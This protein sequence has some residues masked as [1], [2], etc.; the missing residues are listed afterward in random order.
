MDL[1]INMKFLDLDREYEYFDY[2]DA[3]TSVFDKKNFINGEEINIFEKQISFYLGSKYAVAVSSGTDALMVSIMA[4]GIENPV[5]LTTPYSF[6]STVEV[7]LRLN[8]R[9]IVFCDIKD[10][11]NIDIEKAKEII[12]KRHIDI[13]LPVHLF[14]RPCELDDEILSLCKQKG[15][16]VIEDAAQSI[17]S[18]YGDKKVG[19]IGDMGCFSFFPAKTLGCAGDGG[20]V[21]TDSKELYEKMLMIRN[22]GSVEKYE[23]KI[24]GGNFRMDT[25]QAALLSVKLP[26]LDAFINNRSSQ[27][28]SYNLFFMKH[29]KF[30]IRYPEQISSLNNKTRIAYNQYV[31]RSDNRDELSNFLRD[32]GIPTALYY[33]KSLLEQE[34]IKKDFFTEVDFPN[35]KKATKMNLALPIAYLTFE[36]S[37]FIKESIKEFFNE[38]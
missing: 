30:N 9:E 8:S 31:I 12:S 29:Q 3:V 10:D 27:A 22:H 26:H 33:S 20:L 16:I 19:T 24:H 34:C 32:K 21:C 15:V 4:T 7:P 36:E 38:R 37:Q 23:H 5:V 25:L 13:F 2:K 6:I 1:V 18:K 35:V 11:F 28:N 17:G 14:G